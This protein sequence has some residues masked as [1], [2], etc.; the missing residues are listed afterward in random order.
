MYD[1]KEERR[2]VSVLFAQLSGVSAGHEREDPEEMKLAV[3][4]A[5][6]S[7]IAEVE[8]LGG[9]LTA[10]S[11]AGLAA[12]LALPKPMKTTPNERSG[13]GF[14][15]CPRSAHDDPKRPG[16]GLSLRIGIETGSAVVGPLWPAAGAGYGAPG[17]VMETAAALQSA[18]KPGSVLV[19]PATKAATEGI[20]SGAPS[21]KLRSTSAPAVGC[22]L[23]RAAKG[24]S[25]WLSGRTG[26]RTVL[27]H[28][29]PSNRAF[30]AGR[31]RSGRPRPG[32]D[33]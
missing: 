19:G 2:P 3:G 28:G 9:T 11:G 26:S 24:P 1:G 33:R 5:L 18:A 27:P 16:G 13:P 22:R 29:R 4:N 23:P 14:A 12:L 25:P 10:V 15:C 31:A 32:P 7:A 21:I 8:G 20:L 30:D 6:A 17:Q